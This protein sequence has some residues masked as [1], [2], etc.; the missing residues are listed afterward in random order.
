MNRTL[1]AQDKAVLAIADKYV[2]SQLFDR[3]WP[4][5]IGPVDWR[6]YHSVTKEALAGYTRRKPK[7]DKK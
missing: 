1:N 3:K 7:K 4:S 5:D 2:R 6:T